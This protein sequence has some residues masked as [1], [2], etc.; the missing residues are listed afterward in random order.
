MLI[1]ACKVEYKGLQPTERIRH[2]ISDMIQKIQANAPSDSNI[3]VG[4]EK[5]GDQLQAKFKISASRGF[6]EAEAAK[7]SVRELCKTIETDINT[8]LKLWKRERGL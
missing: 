5:I 7:D 6:F 1:D 3:L 2:K 8:Q 4:I